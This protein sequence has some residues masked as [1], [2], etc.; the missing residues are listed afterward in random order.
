MVGESKVGAT[1]FEKHAQTAIQVILVAVT[2]WVGSAV[3]TLRDASIRT[4]EKNTQMR[5]SII[6]LK[7]EISRLSSSFALIAER[8][9]ATS[10]QMRDIETRLAQIERAIG[11]KPK[12]GQ[13]GSQ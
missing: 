10:H 9:F 8:N 2:L 11:R 4:E 1:G 6:E 7:G 3:L 5:E 13:E 12:N